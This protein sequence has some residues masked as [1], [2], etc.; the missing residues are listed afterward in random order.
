MTG[1]WQ[2][3]ISKEWAMMRTA[4]SFFP[5]LRPFIIIEQVRRSMMGH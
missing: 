2:R 3:T 5:L 4:F 1:S